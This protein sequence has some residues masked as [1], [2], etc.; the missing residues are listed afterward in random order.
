[1]CQNRTHSDVREFF[2]PQKHQKQRQ[3]GTGACDWKGERD[4]ARE[5]RMT[6]ADHRLTLILLACA[7]ALRVLVPAG[8]MPSASGGALA[9]EPCPAAEPAP[10]MLMMAHH[11]DASKHGSHKGQHDDCAFAPLTIAFAATQVPATI[12][13]QAVAGEE[14][15]WLVAKAVL[16]TG[17]PDLLPPATGPPAFA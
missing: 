11:H 17:P 6:R 4:V 13:A 14:P 10:S 5:A 16:A 12:A 9:I 7:L 1:M 8:W 3:R 2:C 15:A